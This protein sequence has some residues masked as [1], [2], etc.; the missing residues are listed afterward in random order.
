MISAQTG[1]LLSKHQ[2]ITNTGN[3]GDKWNLDAHNTN[4]PIL[5]TLW[6]LLKVRYHVIQLPKYLVYTKRKSNKHIKDITA[7]PCLLGIIHN[8]HLTVENLH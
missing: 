5:E 8:N 4:T 1:W 3:S 7:L 2:I 6:K